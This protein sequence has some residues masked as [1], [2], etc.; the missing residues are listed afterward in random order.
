MTKIWRERQPI[1]ETIYGFKV[2]TNR[3]LH[4]TMEEMVIRGLKRCHVP[5]R[6]KLKALEGKHAI[7]YMQT[8]EQQQWQG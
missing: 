8:L 5:R 6:L 4:G 3:P 1:L 7:Y 2:T